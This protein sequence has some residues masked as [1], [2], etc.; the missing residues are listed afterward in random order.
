MPVQT[1]ASG[2]SSEAGSGDGVIQLATVTSGRSLMHTPSRTQ[3]WH[4]RVCQTEERALL[5]SVHAN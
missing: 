4:T 3:Q 1:N 5:K 2:G